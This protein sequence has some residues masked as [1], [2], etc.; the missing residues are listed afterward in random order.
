MSYQVITRAA[1]AARPARSRS[2][3]TTRGSRIHWNGPT[4]WRGTIGEH[5]RC[6]SLVRGIQ[7]F[8]MDTRGWADIAYSDVLCPH[9]YV[10]AGRGRGVRTAA[11]G[12]SACNNVYEA[13]C[14]LAGE[15]DPFTDAAKV[16]ARAWINERGDDVG[17]HSSC[18]ST[19]CPGD[20]I[21]AWLRA[22]MPIP[23]PPP[24][25]IPDP[26][27]TEEDDMRR[28]LPH[29]GASYTHVTDRKLHRVRFQ[30][31][32]NDGQL[33]VLHW[34]L[35]TPR[36]ANGKF[37]FFPTEQAEFGIFDYTIDADVTGWKVALAKGN[38]AGFWVIES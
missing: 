19:S 4:I 31:D 7:A 10:F 14:Y 24:Q 37:W 5:S 13:L 25:P 38:S 18:R 8:H 27:P 33:V 29:Q 15:G 35:Y 20:S 36:A 22:G 34:A 12:T 16:T 9:G 17:P 3:I 28:D 26:S 21:R 30:V 32:G 6:Y 1:W 2:T 11:N 23:G